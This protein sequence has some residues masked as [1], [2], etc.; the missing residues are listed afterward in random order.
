MSYGDIES[1]LKSVIPQVGFVTVIKLN[2]QDS[3]VFQIGKQCPFL[4]VT[5]PKDK[6][7]QTYVNGLK[8]IG[9]DWAPE[10]LG[11]TQ[12]PYNQMDI[13]YGKNSHSLSDIEHLISKRFHIHSMGLS[14]SALVCLMKTP[15]GGDHV[16]VKL[17][18]GSDGMGDPEILQEQKDPAFV[19][20][21]HV[22]LHNA[23]ERCR[24]LWKA[25]NTEFSDWERTFA[26]DIGKRLGSKQKLTTKQIAALGR[27]F[28]KYKVPQNATASSIWE[29]M[30][31]I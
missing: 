5:N 13:H 12:V 4:L 11:H 9:W 6:S 15:Y 10:W 31:L 24:Y 22:D 30:D 7:A 16:S 8:P 20:N 2:N 18:N 26:K 19:R 14:D 17:N 23:Y 1:V 3:G 27:L 21:S 25:H 29:Q 28:G